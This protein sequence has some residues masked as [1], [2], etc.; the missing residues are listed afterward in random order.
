M[1]WKSLIEP[2][3]LPL[4]TDFF[5]E[6]LVAEFVESQYTLYYDDERWGTQSE[7]IGSDL[8][9]HPDLSERQIFFQLVLQRLSQVSFIP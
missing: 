6:N 8:A 9:G 1:D 5:P 7:R 3:C 4:G 2:A